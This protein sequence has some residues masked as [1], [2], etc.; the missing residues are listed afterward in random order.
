MDFGFPLL[1]LGCWQDPL[2]A[3]GTSILVI[4]GGAV[5]HFLSALSFSK[6]KERMGAVLAATPNFA[7]KNF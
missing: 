4:F 2:L 7:A 1:S 5:T 6:N 3:D